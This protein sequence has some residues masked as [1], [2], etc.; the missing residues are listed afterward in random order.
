MSARGAQN[1]GGHADMA[2]RAPLAGSFDALRASQLCRRKSRA[3]NGRPLLDARSADSKFDVEGFRQALVALVLSASWATFTSSLNAAL[4]W[5]A[6]SA[7]TLRSRAT[8]AAFKPSMNR[9]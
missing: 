1:R 2:V 8:F 6:R 7:S 3:K 4:S 9:L 5:A